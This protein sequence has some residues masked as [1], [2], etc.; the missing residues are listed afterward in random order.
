VLAEEMKKAADVVVAS[1]AA[2]S[3]LDEST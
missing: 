1:L 2:P 3:A